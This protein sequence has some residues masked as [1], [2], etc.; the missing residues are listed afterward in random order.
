MRSEL[1]AAFYQPQLASGTHF[2]EAGPW[3]FPAAAAFALAFAFAP[4]WDPGCRSLGAEAEVAASVANRPS[5]HGL[6]GVQQPHQDSL[7]PDVGVGVAQP[8]D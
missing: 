4:R 3:G 2:R 7:H 8:S 6:D 1:P 5:S